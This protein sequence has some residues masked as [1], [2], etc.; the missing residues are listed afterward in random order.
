MTVLVGVVAYFVMVDS[1]ASATFL[2][3][4][5]KRFVVDA[6]REWCLHCYRLAL[7]LMRSTGQD[8]PSQGEEEHFEMRHLWAAISDWQVYLFGVV[9]LG[10]VTPRMSPLCLTWC[11]SNKLP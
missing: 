7:N 3:A 1:P 2:T 6:Q 5:E 4:D 10:F 9:S 8:S 11:F